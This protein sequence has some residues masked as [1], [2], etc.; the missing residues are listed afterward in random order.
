MS[1][2]H[3][4]RTGRDSNPRNPCGF[5][6]FRDRL[7]QPLGHLSQ[8]RVPLQ[9][10]VLNRR[11]SDGAPSHG[12]SR[13]RDRLLQ[14][15]GHLSNVKYY[16]NRRVSDGVPSLGFSPGRDRLLQPLGHLSRNIVQRAGCS[17]PPWRGAN[18]PTRAKGSQRTDEF[19][20]GIGFGRRPSE[21]NKQGWMPRGTDQAL[22]RQAF[23]PSPPLAS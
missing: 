13:G 6:G 10:H 11:V 4:S 3:T 5:T 9:P 12:F 21:P 14:P 16:M 2:H 22:A 23:R 17:V 8:P 7:L 15:L 20:R 1:S 19:R 18:L